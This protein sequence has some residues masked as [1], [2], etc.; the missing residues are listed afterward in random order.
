[1]W[2]SLGHKL[3]CCVR[4]FVSWKAAA[5]FW[6][7]AGLPAGISHQHLLPLP[8]W[9]RCQRPLDSGFPAQRPL[10]FRLCLQELPGGL[11]A[12]H[13]SQ[14]ESEPALCC[15]GSR[16]R[17]ASWGTGVRGGGTVRAGQRRDPR[18]SRCIVS[19]DGEP[20]DSRGCVCLVHAH[21]GAGRGPEPYGALLFSPFQ[22]QQ[23]VLQHLGNAR[24]ACYRLLPLPD[25][26]AQKGGECVT[27]IHAVTQQPA[28]SR[29]SILSNEWVAE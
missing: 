15:C 17:S 21:P 6:E 23:P 8:I 26:K 10:G 28:H 24:H 16:S 2:L 5:G 25:L 12:K 9:Q 27:Y 19:K 7:A 18:M 22:K 4:T 1:M 29:C 20:S 14:Q 13:P 11:I 3:S